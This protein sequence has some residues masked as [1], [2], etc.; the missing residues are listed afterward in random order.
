[1]SSLFDEQPKSNFTFKSIEQI[2]REQNE[3]PKDP[4]ASAFNPHRAES[5]I[6]GSFSDV[7]AKPV[8]KMSKDK[9]EQI[10]CCLC[11]DNPIEIILKCGNV[12]CDK[13]YDQIINEGL[14]TSFNTKA[15][16]PCCI[17]PITEYGKEISSIKACSNCKGNKNLNYKSDCSHLICGNCYP[18]L[19]ENYT[20][21]TCTKQCVKGKLQEIRYNCKY[22]KYKNKYL[23]YKNKYINLKKLSL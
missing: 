15:K 11:S 22:L 17:T 8:T 3:R 13:C 10:L 23:K 7:T 12:L 19:E 9:S 18:G 4:A 1:M 16:C 6:F 2:F 5:P 20:C 21:K 14:Y